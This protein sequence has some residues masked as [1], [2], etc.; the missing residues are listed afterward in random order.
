MK[1]LR[2]DAAASPA[3]DDGGAWFMTRWMGCYLGLVVLV[4][5]GGTALGQELHVAPNGRDT[6]PGTAE[7]PLAS[8]AG[9]RDALRRQRPAG[10]GPV[11]VI[12]AD[13][14]YAMA[15]PLVLEPQDG[16][17]AEAPVSYEAAPGA[18]P[19]F[20]GGRVLTGWKV[21]DDGVWTTKVGEA[22]SGKWRFEQLWVNGS[23]ATRAK[24]PNQFYFYIQDLKEEKLTARPGP[25][26][27][28]TI[29]LRPEDFDAV[30]GG[31]TEPEVRAT[32]VVV[33]HNWDNTRRFVDRID[34]EKHLVVSSGKAMQA[35][36]GWKPNSHFIIENNRK[37]L[38]APG[39]WFLAAD[40]TVSYR[41]RPGED[42]TT[43]EVVA[44]MAERFVVLKG[45][46]TEGKFVEHV[47]LKGLAFRHAQY[48][49]PAVGFE[50]QQAAASIE[51]AIQAD[52]ARQVVIED[53]EVGHV[54]TYGMWFRKGCRDVT[55]RHCLV[56]D[57][58][59][60]G[61]R[62]GEMQ[63]PPNDNEATDHVTFENNI[64]QHG[65][66]IFPC[67]VGVWIGASPDNTVVHNDIGDFY[68]T[69]ISAGWRWG[70]DASQAKRNTIAFNHV[71]HLG[72]GLLSDMGGIYTLGPSEGTV[73]KNNVFH[74]IYAYS[75][76]GWG[77]YTD[78]GSTGIL[79]ENNLVYRTKTGSFHQHYGRDNVLR[80]NI[81]AFSKE[82]Q[83]QATR[84]EDHRSFTLENNI[85]V[86]ETGPLLAGPWDQVRFES[87]KN[88]Y[89]QIQGQPVTFVGKTLAEWQAAGHEAGSI[90]A[91]PKFRD[92]QTDDFRLAADSPALALGFRPFDPS[93]AG[94]TG[95]AAWRAKA[96]EAKYRPLEVAPEPPS[97]PVS[98]DYE[99]SE[100][101]QAPSGAE[102]HVENRGDA[103]RVTEATA[104]SGRRS[105]EILD[106]PGLSQRYN[107]HFVYSRFA[108][109][110]G[111]IRNSF[112]LR[113][114]EGTDLNFEWRDYTSG[115]YQ[116]GP[117]FTV[118]DGT[119][120]IG[121]GQGSVAIPVGVWVGLDVAS[122]L[123]G[124]DGAPVW[125]LR[126][127]L[128]GGGEPKVFRDLKPLSDKFRTLTWVGLTSN[129]DRATSFYLDDF[130]VGP[131]TK[132]A[133]ATKP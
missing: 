132:A 95:D 87:G 75:Y 91:D 121:D 115:P 21:G 78:E 62:I 7:Q 66:F 5:A 33:Y 82:H 31:L 98:E 40:G 117:Q 38:D 69:G 61:L 93:E 133:A 20:S 59:A 49:T 71:H 6:N 30:F 72:W 120:T 112:S 109:K 2:R 84:V 88:C 34:R 64:V 122:T 50:P 73:V 68:Y 107:P 108:F 56:H 45:N 42:M 129:A 60:G 116:T 105:V 37:A 4:L 29:R 90:V 39:E 27:R 41:P 35:W 119:L 46:P 28:Q 125:H 13:G 55:V 126:V 52:G 81:L 92:A 106:A 36:N 79:F 48:V 67:A 54:G 15:G 63:A 8:L 24:S 53:C 10:P 96:V 130:S 17:T 14:T 94:V 57:L 26:A 83:L 11:R 111:P 74:D 12:V 9:A 80:N 104:A 124:G 128:P 47:E 118:R 25:E 43:A 85:V 65:G 89:Y 32:Q 97:I 100:V 23:R 127:R 110:T 123:G 1:D 3:C 22:A 51:G 18:R 114:E 44:P 86:W 131:P 101:G 103:I 58:G 70:Y 99:A 77:L 16:G 76:G 102:A 113:V 19:V